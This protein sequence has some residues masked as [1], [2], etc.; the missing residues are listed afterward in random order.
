MFKYALGITFGLIAAAV[1]FAAYRTGYFK[2]VTISSGQKGPFQLY[3]REHLGPYH[4]IIPL[5]EEV[6]TKMKE[7][8]SPCPWAFGRF[9]DDPKIVDHD[10]LRS[11]A[12][13]AFPGT[14]GG[15]LTPEGI[16]S[17]TLPSAEYLLATFNGSPSIGPFV[18]YPK[19]E[20]WCQ[21][22]GYQI[23]SPVVELYKTL[24]DGSILT[25]YLFRYQ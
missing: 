6:E 9:F 2:E 7:T 15:P 23:V 14:E 11:H 12:G 3:Y 8:G 24:P 25:T 20:E 13:C 16:K 19:I 22:Y 10:R 5:I 18:V 21:T 4:K 1:G 17:E